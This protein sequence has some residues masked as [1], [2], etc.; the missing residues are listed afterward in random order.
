MKY[1]INAIAKH[2]PGAPIA[3][4]TLEQATALRPSW[5]AKNSGV[6]HRHRA[7]ATDSLA[8]MGASA[9]RDALAHSDLSMS[10]LDLLLFGSGS[11]D[12][13]IPYNACLLKQALG[14]QGVPFPYYD[15]DAACRWLS[16]L[17]LTARCAPAR[18]LLQDAG[19]P[20]SLSDLR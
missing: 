2:L 7:S 10:D 20:P 4:E 17:R 11:F 18:L 16:L 19:P 9:L 15:V 8:S 12:Y 6:L 3:A 14:A 13:P 1:R 5:I